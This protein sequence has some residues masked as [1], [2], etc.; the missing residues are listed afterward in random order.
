MGRRDK[1]NSMMP[2]FRDVF[3]VRADGRVVYACDYTVTWICVSGERSVT[4][5]K[6]ETFGTNRQ[7][8]GHWHSGFHGV[9]GV[10]EH[11]VSWLLTHDSLP[12]LPLAIDHADGNIDNNHPYNLRAVSASVNQHN[13]RRAKGYSWLK[14]QNKWQA[15]IHVGDRLINL[16]LYATELDARAAYIRGKREFH[17]DCGWDIFQN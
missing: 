17:P 16:G 14:S 12:V 5:L 15:R 2:L 13:Q 7:N 6:G 8:G 10:K 1:L 9:K 11:E 3:E 4:H